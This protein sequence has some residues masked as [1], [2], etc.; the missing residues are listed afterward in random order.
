MKKNNRCKNFLQNFTRR[1]FK[2][3][4]PFSKSPIIWQPNFGLKLIKN[5]SKSNAKQNFETFFAYIISMR[6]VIIK[7]S[8]NQLP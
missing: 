7:P 6:D 1:V 8:K 4:K 3:A 5:L 2:K